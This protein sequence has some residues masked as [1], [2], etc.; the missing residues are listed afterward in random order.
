MAGTLNDRSWIRHALESGLLNVEIEAE[1]ASMDKNWRLTPFSPCARPLAGEAGV[2]PLQA[3]LLIN[4]GISDRP[5]VSAFLSPRLSDMHDPMALKDME[6]AVSLVVEAIERQEK[7]AVYGDYDADGLTSTALL[8]HFFNSVGVSASY[9]IPNRLTEGYGLNEPALRKLREG[10]ARLIVTVDCGSSDGET[11]ERARAHGLR[12][13]VTDHHQ[14]PEAFRPA[15]PVVNPHRPDCRFPF[16]DLAGVGVAFLLAVSVRAALRERHFFRGRPE[17]D[18][19]AYLDL[20]AVGTMADRAPL[21]GQNRTFVRSGLKILQHTRWRGLEALKRVSASGNAPTASDLAFRL[22]PRLNA[23]GRMGGAE[24]AIQILTTQEA[25]LADRLA[26]QIDADNS[27]RQSLEKAILDQAE[28]A[29]QQDGIAGRKTLLLSGE[30]WHPGVLGIVASRLVD[31]YYRP[32][33][34]VSV[35]NGSAIGSARSIRGFN[36]HRALSRLGPLFERFGG[37][38]YAAGFR[39]PASKLGVL[40]VEMESVAQDCLGD[41]ALVQRLPI[42]A[43]LSLGEVDFEMLRQLQPLSPFGEA[44]PEPVFFTRALELRAS[45]VVG[46]RHLKFTVKQGEKVLE[47]IGFGLAEKGSLEGKTV[48]MVFTPEVNR[49]RGEEK[50]QL[51]VL[52]LEEADQGPPGVN[53]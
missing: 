9:Y 27:R 19:R 47:A 7:I 38:A 8:F 11:I 6:E 5:S 53:P 52:D 16:K 18:L 32:A 15:C 14:V 35:Q 31:K 43:E 40:E 37:H 44:N 26:L 45:R 48:N 13:V 46:D 2:T 24:A 41:E 39:L 21:L 3:Q 20:V 28:A 25:L 36:L 51:R 4:R 23:P 49:W 10:G 12:V 42:D 30:D 17:P 33:F 22:A 29:F 50:I 1:A 34:V